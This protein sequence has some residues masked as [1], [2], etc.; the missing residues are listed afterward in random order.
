MKKLMNRIL[1]AGLIIAMA[2]P[3]LPAIAGEPLANS[4]TGISVTD[5]T[6]QTGSWNL[7]TAGNAGRATPSNTQKATASNA[8]LN[9]YAKADYEVFSDTFALKADDT[10]VDVVQYFNNRYSYAHLAFDDTVTFEVT[11]KSG[12]TIKDFDISP[13]SYD[14]NEDAVVEGDRLTFELTQEESRYLIIKIKTGNTWLQNLVI[15]ADPVETEEKPNIMASDVIDITADP[16]GADNRDKSDVSDIIQAAMDELSEAGGGTVYFPA[17]VYKFVY[18]YPKSNVTLYLDEGAVLRGDSDWNHYEWWNTGTMQGPQNIQIIGD[19]QNFSIKGRGMIDAN[20]TVLVKPYNNGKID[21]N[22]PRRKGIIASWADEEGNKPGNIILEGITVKDGTTWT[23]NLKDSEGVTI[24]NVKLLNNDSWV[25][26]DGY[27]ICSCSDVLV[28]QCLGYTGDD[29]FCLKGNT[30]GYV[31]QN[32][33]FSNG[34]AYAEGG[35]GCKVGVQ[36]VAGAENVSFENI[37]VVYGYRGFSISHDEGTAAWSDI[38]FTDIRTEKI[39]VNSTSGQYRAAPFI[40]WTL[41]GGAGPVSNVEITN[42]MIEN[43]SGLKGLIQGETAAGSISDITF[44]DFVMDGKSVTTGNYPSKIMVG[45]NVS[46]VAFKNTFIEIPEMTS[47]EAE[48]ASYGNGASSN[49]A[50]AC[51]GGKLVGNIGGSSKNG[52]CTFNVYAENAGIHEIT[53]YYCTSGSRAFR[54]SVNDT[55]IEE[56]RSCP[57]TGS[58]TVPDSFVMEV[59][60]KGGDNTIRFDNPAGWAPNLDKIEVR[61]TEKDKLLELLKLA[62]EEAGKTD[63]YTMDSLRNLE[64]EIEKSASVSESATATQREKE[65]AYAGLLSAV[66]KLENI[67]ETVLDTTLS[68]FLAA[69]AE[70]ILKNAEKYQPEGIETL[71]QTME[72]LKAALEDD[73]SSQEYLNSLNLSLT[74]AMQNLNAVDD[75]TEADRNTLL[76]ILRLAEAYTKEHYTKESYL[77]FET[78][79]TDARKICGDSAAVQQDLDKAVLLLT[80]AVMQ[81]E[82]KADKSQLV[83]W[84]QA[85]EAIEKD[86]YTAESLKVLQK[87]LEAGKKLMEEEVAEADQ[88]RVA[89]ACENLKKATDSLVKKTE[90]SG[91][92]SNGSSNSKDNNSR[93]TIFP[94]SE[95]RSADWRKDEK[96]WWIVTGDNTYAR[97]EWKR[98][99][100]IWYFFDETGYMATGWRKLGG[101][102]YWL[103]PSDGRMKAG[104]WI[105]NQNQWYYLGTDGKMKTGWLEYRGN[106]Y[107]LSETADS[108]YGHMMKNEST[109]DGNWVNEQGIKQ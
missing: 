4:V 25:H 102:W 32:I 58:F 44:T 15:A 76:S 31:M 90:A 92:G 68:E 10:E 71:K 6:S 103:N 73:N 23:I 91:S 29:V 97:N 105:F 57:S 93:H 26:S 13:H 84:I 20:S 9:V 16:Y 18:L 62:R 94:S 30:E 59:Y 79:F 3:P 82:R 39:Y 53:V 42:C 28:D 108:Y 98:V 78:A 21:G 96:G 5:S 106:W 109:P 48:S 43:T 104:E 49:S 11:V 81:L 66:I 33:T 101:D 36:S 40:I 2:M 8:A 100:G 70:D 54:I 61:Q 85:A 52:Y 50:G 65:E 107:Y 56:S 46:K 17:G 87:A 83:K 37:D 60:L 74:E 24:Q 63:S 64:T 86:G 47:Y 12:E 89:E 55:V 38:S 69:R 45:S 27:D 41:G 99:D 77:V 35:A 67:V 72:A 19:V 34:V 88:D 51:S 80:E 7:A 14:L 1:A 95:G 75:K 22:S